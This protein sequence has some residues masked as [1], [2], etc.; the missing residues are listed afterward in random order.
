[1]I[2]GGDESG[3]ISLA[4]VTELFPLGGHRAGQVQREG[5]AARTCGRVP[6]A[7]WEGQPSRGLPLV[8]ETPEQ[9]LPKDGEV[10]EGQV[11][12]ARI[13]QEPEKTAPAPICVKSVVSAHLPCPQGNTQSSANRRL[14]P[15]QSPSKQGYPG[16]AEHLLGWQRDTSRGG[17]GKERGKNPNPHPQGTECCSCVDVLTPIRVKS[18]TVVCVH[19]CVHAHVCADAC[20]CYADLQ[21]NMLPILSGL[22]HPCP[23]VTCW[24]TDI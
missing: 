24:D 14:L 8:E 5:R 10:E 15:G 7:P 23:Q 19:V 3:D 21:C 12:R 22:D 2:N 6:G 9:W 4:P 18:H 20:G 16:Q 13:P 17:R 1:M 11:H